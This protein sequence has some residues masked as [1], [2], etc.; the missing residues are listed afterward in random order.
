MS[1]N[2]N[3]NNNSSSNSSSSDSSE[4]SLEELQ[5]ALEAV[6]R[7]IELE[8]QS[9][10]LL[11][12]EAELKRAIDELLQAKA[13]EIKKLEMMLEQLYNLD[14]AKARE[15][16]RRIDELRAYKSF[17]KDIRESINDNFSITDPKDRA[18][19][20]ALMAGLANKAAQLA[21]ELHP[22]LQSAVA[23]LNGVAHKMLDI[24]KEINP[25]LAGHP[26]FCALRLDPINLAT[27]NFVYDKEDIEI[28]GAFPLSFTRTF[29]TMGG[30]DGPLG[31]NW[32]H[33]F[34]VRLYKDEQQI[35]IMF[36]DGHVETYTKMAEEY[37]VT[38]LDRNNALIPSQN[39]EG[40]N[41]AYDLIL[42]NNIRYRFDEFGA[43]RCIDDCNANK[44]L[45]DYEGDG[46]LLSKVT[47]LSGSLS[48]DYNEDGLLI[49]VKDHTGRKV[50]YKYEN[51]QLIEAILPNEASTK[52]EYDKN[53]RISKITN[54]MGI[55]YVQNKYDYE[56]R[57]IEQILT[58]D[59]KSTLSYNENEMYTTVTEANGNMVKY[60]RDEQF[61][62]VKVEYSDGTYEEYEY[63][64]ESQMTK[65]VDRNKNT[66]CYTYDDH[67]NITSVSD[68]LGN[69]AEFEYNNH[70]KPTKIK[71]A[72]KAEINNTYDEYGNLTE[73]ID[74][75]GN[76][77]KFEININGKPTSMI[78]PDGRQTKMIYD[79]RHNLISITDVS[80]NVTNYEYDKLNRVTKV[81]NPK[82]GAVSYEYN[83]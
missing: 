14:Q 64:L 24:A 13:E 63:N 54:P 21:G 37:Y 10:E 35:N 61:R 43:L 32:T 45:F 26:I 50:S 28:Q 16:Q 79:E 77:I 62:S 68:P 9:E 3:R 23:S 52:Y 72:N 44:T 71:T 81:I 41:Y 76:K 2:R 36:E 83:K 19:N 69:K 39:R 49:S 59:G 17:L 65:Y 58:D 42:P 18:A 20:L 27:G 51:K 70:N 38:P 74:P 7:A 6:Q 48:F 75:L 22:R 46:L 1:K 67:G 47:N 29:N 8:G 25:S 11:R 55:E 78:L 4:D 57:T 5:E 12:A 82:G 80:G 31:Y 60:F 66:I 73:L 30:F 33:N 15:I 40:E 56:G 53:N 34:N